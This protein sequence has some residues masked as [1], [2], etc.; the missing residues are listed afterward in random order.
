[1]IVLVCISLM[2]NELEHHF[3]KVLVIRVYS[4]TKC[5]LEAFA[6]CLLDYMFPLIDF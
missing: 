3:K 2:T 4:F 6:Q 1:M 5:L